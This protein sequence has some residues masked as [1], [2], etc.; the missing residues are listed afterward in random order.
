[1]NPT[2]PVTA[3]KAGGNPK[4]I[5]EERTGTLAPPANHLSLDSDINALLQNPGKAKVMGFE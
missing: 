4:V 3:T 2:K 5:Q 1:M